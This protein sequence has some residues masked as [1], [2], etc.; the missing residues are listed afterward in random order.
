MS[1]NVVA[2]TG[3]LAGDPELRFTQ[4]GKALTTFQIRVRERVSG[5]VKFDYHDCQAW[6]NTAEYIANHGVK[7]TPIEIK[8]RLSVDRWVAADGTKRKATKVVAES[9]ELKKTE[10][11]DNS[12]EPV[13]QPETMTPIVD[14]FDG[15]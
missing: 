10:V 14:P 6:A 15:E 8:G 12:A 9:A 13:E 4:S 5:E 11:S 1:L 3:W 2:L 7:G